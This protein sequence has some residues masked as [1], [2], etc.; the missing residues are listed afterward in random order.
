MISNK[1]EGVII[2][3]YEI[4]RKD[5]TFQIYVNAKRVTA[6]L[7][8]YECGWERCNPNHSFGPSIRDY[9]LIHYLTKGK[10]YYRI[11][12]TEYEVK[13]GDCFLI[14]PGVAN[15]YYADKDDPWEYYW[16][17]FH[18]LEVRNILESC[19]LLNNFVFRPEHGEE[20]IE[21]MK[22]IAQCDKSKQASNYLMLSKLYHLFSIYVGERSKKRDDK[23]FYQKDIVGNIIRYIQENYASDIK[24]NN[25][26]KK[27]GIN[28]SHLYRIFK[29][30][31]GISL[32]EYIIEVRLSKSRIFLKYKNASVKEVAEKS[33]FKDYGN[34][35][36]TFKKKYKLTPKQYMAKPYE[37]VNE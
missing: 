16:V 24:V 2:T 18:G 33:G 9:Y 26:A 11:N 25:L 35:L 20:V 17:G 10:G 21:I 19:D 8:I 37:I 27:F 15:F 3:M 12:D 31:M 13:T 22:Q 6:D 5:P 32:Q 28:R 29:A 34:F 4:E 14:P 23:V 1:N 7:A 36:K 30:K